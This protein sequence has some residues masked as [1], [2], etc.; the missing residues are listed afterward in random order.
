[1]AVAVEMLNISKFFPGVVANDDVSLSV[2]EG[3]ILGLIG[4]NGAGKSTMMN[5]LYG[6][7]EPDLGV[8]KLFGKEVRIQSPTM[9]I[10]LGIGM[11]HQHFMLM[12]N[13]S[14]LQNIILGKAPTK[15]GLIDTKAAKDKITEIMDTYDLP[16]KLDEKVYQLSVG[17]KQRVEIIKALYREAKV[18]IM[19]EPTAVLTPTETDKLLDVLRL[20]KSKG[21]A[22][23]FITHKLREVMAITDKIV[24]MRKGLVTGSLDTAE[25]ST[26][27][28][29][30]MMV[31][32]KVN[33]EIPRKDYNPDEN[34]LEVEAVRALNQRGLPALNGVSFQVARGE[35]V[36]IAGVEGNGQTELIEVVSGM[37]K[38]TAGQVHFKHQDITAHTVRQRREEGMSHIPEDRL[39]MGSAANCTIRDNL[40]LNRYYQKPYC[41]GGILDNKKLHALSED[42][43]RDF[44][45]KTPDSDYK[46]GT[47][48]GGNMQKV[49]FAREME[50]DPDLLIAAQP[51]RG[52]DIGAIE[53][54][55]HKIIEVRDSGRG[56]LLVSAELDEILSLSDR[57]LVMY[58]GE[59]MAEF[60]RGEADE[61]T[62]AVYMTGAKRQGGDHDEK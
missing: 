51:T 40:I 17:E 35:V 3:E 45:V 16:V 59:I 36:G 39:K 42:L 47:L 4:E 32:R 8:I 25:A 30:N 41:N 60:K 12:P 62:I 29:S 49:I 2:K 61:K 26:E 22:I 18:L 54:I 53:S 46:L 10:K 38:P 34:V 13:L 1:M 31:G 58:E 33:L 24:V 15:N 48:S 20:L 57:I 43:C 14:V 7:M 50:A 11:V 21:C 9:A 37:L 55:H 6:M 52:V 28:L 23:I 44:E 19:D 5:M 27:G 56:V